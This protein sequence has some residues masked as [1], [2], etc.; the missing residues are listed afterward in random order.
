LQE[1]LGVQVAFEVLVR[2]WAESWASLAAAGIE[3]RDSTVDK[4][5]DNF[6]IEN[7]LLSA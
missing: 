4:A 7:R 1:L 5:R 6:H 3:I 2:I